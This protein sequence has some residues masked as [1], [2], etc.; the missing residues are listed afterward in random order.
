MPN[1]GSNLCSLIRV[2]IAAT[3][4]LCIMKTHIFKYIENFTNKNWK[5]SDKYSDIFHISAQTIDCRY[6]LELP[7]L[8]SSNK[9]PQ[10]MFLSRNM[11]NNAYPC[12]PHIK[13]GFKGVKINYIG[14]VWWWAIQ[15][16]PREDSDQTVWMPM[17]TWIF[18]GRTC[19]SS[20][21]C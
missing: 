9:Y 20:F 1:K 13:V 12:K 8:G 3:L 16:V 4:H 7:C 18:A 19:P 21:F 17:L 5:F 15:N 2:L 6:L 14:M 11:K 10:S